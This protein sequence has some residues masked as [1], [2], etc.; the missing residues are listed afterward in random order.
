[1]K[2]YRVLKGTVIQG[3]GPVEV[4][5]VLEL[6]DHLA[7]GMILIGRIELIRSPEV[8]TD[9]APETATVDAEQN[10]TDQAPEV[11][12]NAERETA[13]GRGRRK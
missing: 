8:A 10:G 12:T 5:A 7:R 4:G 3:I 6:P 1:M 13:T 11:A 2:E 9:Q